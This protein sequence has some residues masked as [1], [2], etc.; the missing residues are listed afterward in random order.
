MCV[1]VA[2]PLFLPKNGNTPTSNERAPLRNVFLGFSRCKSDAIAKLWESAALS[3]IHGA[4]PNLCVC[5][6]LCMHGQFSLL[7]IC[8]WIWD[9]NSEWLFMRPLSIPV[10][11]TW[12]DCL[13]AHTARGHSQ[14]QVCVDFLML[15]SMF[16]YTNPLI[17]SKEWVP[18]WLMDWFINMRWLKEFHFPRR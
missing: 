5:V 9:L 11:K 18:V 8:V 17:I 1:C 12:K 4:L 6:C 7:C 15:V 13:T 3:A 16:R 14:V 2:I 10:V